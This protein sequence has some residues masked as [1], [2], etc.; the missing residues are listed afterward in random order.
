M[1]KQ[2]LVLIFAVSFVSAGFVNQAVHADTKTWSSSDGFWHDDS[3]WS[4]SGVPGSGDDVI[5]SPYGGVDTI[6]NFTSATG[7]RSANSLLINSD[8]ASTISFLQSGG[9]LTISRQI[10]GSGS[11]SGSS[12]SGNYVLSGGSLS[13]EDEIIGDRYDIIP[14]IYG[15]FTQTGGT[16]TVTNLIISRVGSRGEY[17]L[18]GGSLL[19]DNEVI[20]AGEADFGPNS[21][22]IFIQSG[23]THIVNHELS[24]GAHGLGT[25]TLHAGSLSV[26][27]ESIGTSFYPI[28]RSNGI[29]T[30]NDGTHTVSDILS[31]GVGANALGTYNLNAGNLSTKSESIGSAIYSYPFERGTGIFTQS[32]GTHT[33][34]DI[35]S[36]GLGGLGTYN[37]NAGSLST[38]SESI[39]SSI[40]LYPVETGGTGIFTQSGGTHTVS[41]ILSIG[42]EGESTGKYD[43]SGGSLSAGSENIGY[44]GTLNQT[45]GIN[46]AQMMIN[47]GAYNLTGGTF[48]VN[49]SLDNSGTMN[50]AGG[51]TTVNGN[52]TNAASGKIEVAHSPAI[53]TGDVVNNG[54]FKSTH[55]T[56]TFT[57]SYTENGAYISDPSINNFTN[58]IIGSSGYLAGGQGNEWHIAG[59]F[60]NHSL[61]NT[62]WNT[63]D[64]DLF[65][66]GSGMKDF[67]LAGANLGASKLGFSNNFAFGSLH[68]AS[69]VELTVLDGNVIP[70]AAM[71][72]DLVSLGGGIGQLSHIHSDFNIYYDPAAA[73]NEYLLGKTYALDGSG[74]LAPA[75]PEPETYAMLLFGL[76]V[77]GFA[78]RRREQ[79]VQRSGW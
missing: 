42:N 70:G 2:P 66:D 14:L 20:G 57:G 71:Y 51:T 69:G 73:G 75:V 1:H 62:L 79:I 40:Y 26:N 8:T 7:N 44:S 15:V 17:N 68:L 74:V 5:V 22:G 67:Y 9:S 33:V 35:L 59:S 41:G 30:Q 10:I 61:Q 58:L 36:I 56:V 45:G 76:S 38:N 52:V 11:D 27:S 64:A 46:T 78:V 60:E 63:V 49:G 55:A 25:Y 43:L 47:N 77:L 12:G 3:S 37:L 48:V 21:N 39:G 34:S 50:L 31:I 6:L 28:E 32:G 16:N 13:A 23:G 53:F 54:Q 72:V 65:F 19:A 18:S 24:I 4:P 29:F